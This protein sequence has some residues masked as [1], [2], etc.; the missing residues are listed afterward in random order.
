MP[1]WRRAPQ[2]AVRPPALTLPKEAIAEIEAALCH[3]DPERF[4]RAYGLLRR[5]NDGTLRWD[6][7]VS[8]RWR[9]R[10][11]LVPARFGRNRGKAGHPVGQ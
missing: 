1:S 10:V 5:L 7:R 9:G 8:N 2:G 6:D 4:A 11:P 3:P